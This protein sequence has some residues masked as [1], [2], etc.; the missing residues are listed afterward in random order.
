MICFDVKFQQH[1]MNNMI[2][3]NSFKI[4]VSNFEFRIKRIETL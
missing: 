4:K 3:Y 2:E 1:F